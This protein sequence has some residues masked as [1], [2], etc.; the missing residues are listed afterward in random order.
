MTAGNEL[1]D[2]GIPPFEEEFDE[3]VVEVVLVVV[4]LVGLEVTPLEPPDTV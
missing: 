1:P 3:E 2:T 4:A